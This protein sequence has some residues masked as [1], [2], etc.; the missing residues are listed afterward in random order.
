VRSLA[1]L[2][3]TLVYHGKPEL[4]QEAVVKMYGCPVDL[5]AHGVAHRVLGEHGEGTT[6]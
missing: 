1:C 4:S 6:C 2:N 5:I 3:Q